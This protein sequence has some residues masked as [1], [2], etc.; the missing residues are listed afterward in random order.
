M[1]FVI[2]ASDCFG[3]V[4]NSFFYLRDLR[5]DLLNQVMLGL[6]QSLDAPGHFMQFAQHRVLARRDFV[7]PP[8][9]DTPTGH[10][11]PGQGE[12]DHVYHIWRLR[13]LKC[14]AIV[15]FACLRLRKESRCRDIASRKG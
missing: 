11:E 7:H 1:R 10:P 14:Q 2:I 12:N 13:R 6:G 3:H 9:T 5:M 4:L 15:L 8:E